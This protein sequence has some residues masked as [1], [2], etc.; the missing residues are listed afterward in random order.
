MNKERFDSL[1]NEINDLLTRVREVM[2]IIGRE[3]DSGA[4]SAPTDEDQAALCY[5]LPDH[6]VALIQRARAETLEDIAAAGI[7]RKDRFQVDERNR[8][9]AEATQKMAL[10]NMEK[11]VASHAKA[12]VVTGKKPARKGY[13][14]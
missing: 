5:A 13:S 8:M 11:L 4:C 3:V 7:I 9:I 6:A 10:T 14:K 2:D 12:V 1:T